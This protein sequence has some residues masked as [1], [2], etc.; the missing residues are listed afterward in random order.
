MTVTQ[1]KLSSHLILPKNKIKDSKNIRTKR[2]W[3]S[4]TPSDTW[5]RDGD[6]HVQ[7]CLLNGVG[8]GDQVGGPGMG[9]G[10]GNGVGALEW[11]GGWRMGWGPRGAGGGPGNRLRARQL[12]GGPGVGWGLVGAGEWDGGPGVG[13]T[14]GTDQVPVSWSDIPGGG[15]R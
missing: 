2:E 5:G 15:D 14:S 8:P 12:E 10:P 1:R 9:W 6:G 3:F 11:G 4:S 13:W 7:C